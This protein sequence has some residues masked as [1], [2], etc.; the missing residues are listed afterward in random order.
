MIHA[1]TITL[2]SQTFN[3]SKY[4][5]FEIT[6]NG[7]KYSQKSYNKIDTNM[8]LKAQSFTSLKADLFQ[9]KNRVISSFRW[10]LSGTFP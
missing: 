10:C 3:F 8:I 9:N 6:Y 1:F 2:F 7:Q 5:L 4:V